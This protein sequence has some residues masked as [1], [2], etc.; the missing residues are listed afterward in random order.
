MK[1]KIIVYYTPNWP[2]LGKWGGIG[3]YTWQVAKL[4]SSS[5]SKVIIITHRAE[6]GIVR[7]RVLQRPGNCELVQLNSIESDDRKIVSAELSNICRG[8][9]DKHC[10]QQ[11]IFEFPEYGAYG[12]VFQRMCPSAKTVVRLHTPRLLTYVYNKR[13]LIGNMMRLL[14]SMVMIPQDFDEIETVTRASVVT[15]PS[16][17]VCAA[18]RKLRW[19]PNVKVRVFPNPIVDYAIFCNPEKNERTVAVGFVGRLDWRKGAFLIPP[20][21]KEVNRKVGNCVFRIYGQDEGGWQA[22]IEKRNGIVNA[23][24]EFYGG[25]GYEKLAEVYKDLDVCVVLSQFESWGYVPHEALLAGTPLVLSRRCG[26]F[27]GLTSMPG[28][29]ICGYNAK[30]FAQAVIKLISPKTHTD[31][32]RGQLHDFTNHVFG[33]VE[34]GE[35]YYSIYFL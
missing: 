31:V 32:T 24:L 1:D 13:P 25:L 26:I 8:I 34:L 16:E 19:L 9:Y 15:A 11:L 27:E 7:D 22:F 5:V 33:G 30:Q 2:E 29:E 18:L 6:F 17:L 12:L 21:I 10:S 28:I 35:K 4:I 3:S 14:P 23:N 20:V